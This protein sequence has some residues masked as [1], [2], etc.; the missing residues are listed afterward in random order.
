M[1]IVRKQYQASLTLTNERL[2][3]KVADFPEQS[4]GSMVCSLVDVTLFD[5]TVI[6]QVPIQNG[7]L[8]YFYDD[9]KIFFESDIFDVAPSEV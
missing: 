7:N 1:R 8:V 5:G 4:M 6:E 3:E 2:I 9:M